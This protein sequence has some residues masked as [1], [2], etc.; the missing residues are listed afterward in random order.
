M[1]GTA[2]L[3]ETQ[4]SSYRFGFRGEQGVDSVLLL[5]PLGKDPKRDD[6]DKAQI[7]HVEF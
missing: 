1:S 5:A 7:K 6:D 3:L 4:D 2:H